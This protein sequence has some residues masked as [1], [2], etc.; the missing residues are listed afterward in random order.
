MCCT[1]PPSQL[2]QLCWL[3][4]TKQPIRSALHADGRMGKRQLLLLS[5]TAISDELQSWKNKWTLLAWLSHVS[6][7]LSLNGCFQKWCPAYFSWPL[8]FPKKVITK[9]NQCLV[10]GMLNPG[11][12]RTCHFA[13][14]DTG[15][16]LSSVSLNVIWDQ[17][18]DVEISFYRGQTICCRCLCSSC[19]YGCFLGGV[20][21]SAAWLVD[22]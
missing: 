21:T 20:A 5:A 19:S 1:N 22:W 14:V 16:L 9:L 6:K 4:K 18:S 10:Q 17:H 11:S 13:S 8:T 7:D 15:E 12:Q 2:P 3:G